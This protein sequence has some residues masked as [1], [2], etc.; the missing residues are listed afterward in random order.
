MA[1]DLARIKRNVA[2]MA[3]QSAPEAD[4]DA[5]IASEGT[6]IDEVRA[7]RENTATGMKPGTREYAD[8]ARQ[9]AMAGNALPQVSAD[10]A[11]M[12]SPLQNPADAEYRRSIDQLRTLYPQ[13]DAAQFDEFVNGK[14][15]ISPLAQLANIPLLGSILAP[16]Q[17]DIPGAAQPYNA[18]QIAQN[19][20]LF[21]FGDEIGA[22][23]SALASG[24][25]GKGYPLWEQANRARYNL[26]REKAGFLG[27]VASVTG[28]LTSMGK[29]SPTNAAPVVANPTTLQRVGA[30]GK[31]M[32]ISGATGAV[33]GGVEGFGS[34]EGDIESR[35]EG[36]KRGAIA[37]GVVGSA[38]PLVVRG[39]MAPFQKAA[40]TRAVNAAIQN[41]PDAA[42]MATEASRLFKA[43]KSSGVGVSP[44]RFGTF[45][46]DLARK[47]KDADIDRD[48]DGSAWTVYERLIE[49]AQE[50]FQDQSALSLSRLHNLRQK[51]QDVAFDTT[52][53]G[54]TRKF[55]GDLVDGID[56]LIENLKPG[57][58]T[59]P[60]NLLGKGGPNSAPNMLMDAISTWSRAKKIGTVEGAIRNAEFYVSGAESGL[61]NQFAQILRN[62]KTRRQF[63]QTEIEAMRKVVNGGPLDAALRLIGS[64][65]GL[66]SIAVGGGIG[67]AAGAVAGAAAGAASRKIL[68]ATRKAAAN[69]AAKI[70]ATPSVP[71]FSPTIR[72]VGATPLPLLIPPL[73]GNQ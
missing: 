20:Q 27:D 14:K 23:A 35:L 66:G 15:S 56:D 48:L 49:L 54:R 45:A 2:K 32:A 13:M 18:Q 47:V 72:Q 42:E 43:S 67:G 71:I 38:A 17:A 9:Q 65:R 7:Y 46:R 30:V 8:W 36:A 3:A 59:G 28:T 70:V 37:G 34:G 4:I 50:G 24:D 31:D 61:R 41:A 64:F 21:S 63:N 44:Q 16:G 6:T 55:A 73:G 60:S 11:A 19:D 39:I 53:R 69:R 25:F 26:G 51:A 29:A 40:Q 1:A 58:M 22:A 57:D 10:P 12:A 33:M 62:P 68:E 52:S 5:Y